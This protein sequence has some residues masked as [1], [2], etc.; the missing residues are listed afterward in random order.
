MLF[1]VPARRNPEML[2]IGSM[3]GHA[4]TGAHDLVDAAPRTLT[5]PAEVR[6]HQS[7]LPEPLPAG[8]SARRYQDLAAAPE[9]PDLVPLRIALNDSEGPIKATNKIEST[10]PEAV[11]AE[12]KT[13]RD[14]KAE[15]EKGIPSLPEAMSISVPERVGAVLLIAVTVVIGLWPGLLLDWIVPAWQSPLFEGLKKAGGLQ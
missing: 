9:S 15:I 1:R 12:L 11:V 7:G 4:G 3:V 14:K 13:L 10:F 8:E 5:Q 6:D 2:V